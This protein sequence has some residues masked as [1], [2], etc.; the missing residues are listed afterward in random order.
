MTDEMNDT[1][2]INLSAEEW[3]ALGNLAD[4]RSILIKVPI[5]ALQ[6]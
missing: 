6:C 2:Q 1:T 3:K 4:D 5:M